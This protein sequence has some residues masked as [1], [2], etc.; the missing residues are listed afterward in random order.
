MNK[1]LKRFFE[2][3]NAEEKEFIPF[4]AADN[5]GIFLRSAINEL[6][7]YY[8]NMSRSG[9]PTD[10]QKEQFY[11]LQLGVARL[12]KLSLESR[13]SFDVPV[14]MFLRRRDMTVPVLEIAAGLGMI[15]H[16]RRVAQTVST[17]LCRIEQ[18][19]ENDFLI[20]LPSVL[21]DDEYYERSVSEHYQAESRKRFAELLQSDTG[22]ELDVKVNKLLTK[23]VYPYET[24]FIGYDADPLLDGYFFGLA[25]SEV[26]RYEGYDTF[27]YATSFGGTRFQ[28]YV[29]AMTYFISLSIRHE[30]F[31]EALVAKVPTVKLENVLTISSD[32]A[33]FIESIRDAINHFGSVYS[34]SE[35]IT[36]DEAKRIFEVLSFTGKTQV[37]SPGPPRRCQS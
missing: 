31:A 6:D 34:G 17:G 1:P 26:Q 18:V 9:N 33:G 16:G 32:T 13:P 23:L 5:M 24:H 37:F 4:L 30:R 7:W 27:N 28:K 22:K 2:A 35:E 20:T 21:P 14:V 3:L 11:L 36:L 29:L 19:G 8:Y 25:F 15:E 12:M 10:E